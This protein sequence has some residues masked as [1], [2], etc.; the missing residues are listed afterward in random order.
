[1]FVSEII[2][3]PPEEYASD[4]QALVYKTLAELEIPFERVDT[5]DAVTMDDCIEIEKKLGCKV[6]KTLFLCNR[7][8]TNF[9]LFVTPGDKPFVTKDFGK[10]LGVSRVSFAPSD[11]LFDMMQ[12][13]VGATTV[14]SLLLEAAMDVRII[15]DKDVLGKDDYGCTDGTFNCYMK[16]KTADIIE[17]LIPHTGHTAEIIEV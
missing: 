6:V 14:Y 2:T 5:G 15:I 10:A 7:Q 11:L 16:V 4:L 17:K 1:M 12:T 3:A 9:Y 8:K 13:K